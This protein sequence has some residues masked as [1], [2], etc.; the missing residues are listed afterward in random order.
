MKKIF[1]YRID[2]QAIVKFITSDEVKHSNTSVSQ[3]WAA[4]D[5]V[6][7]HK[8]QLVTKDIS[9]S[10]VNFSEALYDA[11]LNLVLSVLTTLLQNSDSVT[12][13]LEVDFTKF[14][15]QQLLCFQ[16]LLSEGIIV[17]IQ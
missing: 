5:S 14:S 16:T 15:F 11:R 13:N 9:E 4:D 8:L 10:K 3:V 12:E 2:F 7:N 1:K 17:E 6:N